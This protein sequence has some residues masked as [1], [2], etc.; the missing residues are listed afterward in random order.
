MGIWF[1]CEL[2]SYKPH[3]KQAMAKVDSKVLGMGVDTF[4]SAG[5]AVGKVLDSTLD[6]ACILVLGRASR[7]AGLMI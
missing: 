2:D 6:S 7:K 1:A 3:S 5:K 4:V